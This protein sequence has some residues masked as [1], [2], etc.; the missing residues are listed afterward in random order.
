VEYSIVYCFDRIG[1]IDNF[2]F[3]EAVAIQDF[4]AVNVGKRLEGLKV[5]S[6]DY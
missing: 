2:F 4:L 6:E 5:I 3:D 1:Y